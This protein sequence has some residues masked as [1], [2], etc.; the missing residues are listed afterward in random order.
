MP[1][2]YIKYNSTYTIPEYGNYLHQ[3]TVHISPVFIG[4]QESSKIP[5][6]P[7]KIRSVTGTAIRSLT[8]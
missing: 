7:E 4:I 3:A 6:P 5:R 8:V 2:L 1:P